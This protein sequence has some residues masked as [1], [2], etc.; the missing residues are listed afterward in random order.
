M[1]IQ[2]IGVENGNLSGESLNS[3]GVNSPR[4]SPGVGPCEYLQFFSIG[5]A[6]LDEAVNKLVTLTL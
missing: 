2:K 5:I 6:P 1:N 3:F 4:R